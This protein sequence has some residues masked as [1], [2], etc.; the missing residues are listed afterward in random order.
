MDEDIQIITDQTRID[1]IKKFFFQNRKNIIIVTLSILAL[2]I[3]FFS[4]V[5]FKE[6]KKINLANK[7]NY[8]T[9][10]FEKDKNKNIENE[11]ISIVNQKDSTYSLLAL[12]FII[13]NEIVKDKVKVNNL[14]DIVINNTKLDKE[15]KN[16]TI[17]KKALYNS[18]SIDENNLLKILNPIVNS[19]SI[20]RVH[21]LY[22]MAEYFLSKNE[23][24]KA[25]DFLIQILEIENANPN[26]KKEAQKRINRDFSD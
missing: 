1:R 2:I 5:E 19:D 18:E 17:F 11:L 12:N 7:Y 20:W 14:F 23:T 13:D 25:K 4:Y 10:T 6:K 22:L 24:K 3:L 16:L 9:D 8:I 26:I 21:S 15:I